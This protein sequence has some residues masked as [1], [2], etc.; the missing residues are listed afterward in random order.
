MGQHTHE[1]DRRIGLVHG[2]LN[3]LATGL[4]IMS[5]FDRR[6]AGTVG[7]RDQR[8]QLRHHRRRQ[9]MGGHWCSTRVSA[10]TVRSTP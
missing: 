6:R 4:Y 8:A 9:L 3:G 10:S 7:D 1:E 2:L 5:W